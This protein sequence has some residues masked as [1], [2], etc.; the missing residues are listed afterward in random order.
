[1]DK[2]S[3][4]LLVVFFPGSAETNVGWVGNWMVIRWPVVSRI[5]LPKIIKIW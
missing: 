4:T 5:F 3:D 1:L 2:K